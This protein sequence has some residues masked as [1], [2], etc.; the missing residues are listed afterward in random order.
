[1]DKFLPN[2]T[3][4]RNK[5]T[6][7]NTNKTYHPNNANRT[8]EKTHSTQNI[9]Q[10]RTHLPQ[11]KESRF[12]R[13]LSNRLVSK[14]SPNSNKS[15]GTRKRDHNIHEKHNPRPLGTT[16]LA[17]NAPPTRKLAYKEGVTPVPQIRVFTSIQTA[18]V[19]GKRFKFEGIYVKTATK[20]ESWVFH[21]LVQ[22]THHN[23]LQYGSIFVP[24]RMLENDL[25]YEGL[26]NGNFN[27]AYRKKPQSTQE[28]QTT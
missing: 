2:R 28:K 21:L 24:R 10:K 26:V 6:K 14:G 5:T 20:H 13:N 18:T 15:P 9:P 16:T 22:A 11:H 27:F 19:K 17:T 12:I 1:M 3:D 4:Q 23:N 25:T 8:Q 7:K